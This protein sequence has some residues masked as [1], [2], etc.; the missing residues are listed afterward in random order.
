MCNIKIQT[1]K[2]KTFTFFPVLSCVKLYW[3]EGRH[4]YKVILVDLFE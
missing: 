2:A 1:D 4:Q 3:R